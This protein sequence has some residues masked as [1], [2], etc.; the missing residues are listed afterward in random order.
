M[1][2]LLEIVEKMP[3]N[4]LV[5]V[6]TNH[7]EVFDTFKELLRR[8]Q[9]RTRHGGVFNTFKEQPRRAQFRTSHGGVFDTFKSS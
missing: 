8:A 2:E 5:Q 1:A 9:L 4:L 3:D 6:K 7:G